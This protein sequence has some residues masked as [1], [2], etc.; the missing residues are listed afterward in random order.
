MYNDGVLLP[1]RSKSLVL[2][3]NAG[4]GYDEAVNVSA[5]YNEAL[6]LSKSITYHAAFFT[7]QTQQ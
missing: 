1:F 7:Q 2:L 4:F 5:G 6:E 3:C